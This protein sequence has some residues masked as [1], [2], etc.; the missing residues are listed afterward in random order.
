[1]GIGKASNHGYLSSLQYRGQ[2]D[3]CKSNS[4]EAFRLLPEPC[5]DSLVLCGGGDFGGGGVALGFK[6]SVGAVVAAG[7]GGG[8]YGGE[9]RGQRAVVRILRQGM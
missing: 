4:G 3:A 7:L 9:E 8:R 6:Q 2:I 5:G 1:M